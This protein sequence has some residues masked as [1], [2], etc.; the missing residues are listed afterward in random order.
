MGTVGAFSK[1]KQDAGVNAVPQFPKGDDPPVACSDDF[2]RIVERPMKLHWIPW[3]IGATL[4]CPV[5][6]GDH[7][8]EL[9][10]REIFQRL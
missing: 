4:P 5:T 10:P 1:E 6:N 9:L 3:E 2:G 7:K 8:I